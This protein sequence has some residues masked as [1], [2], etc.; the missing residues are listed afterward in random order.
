[1]EQME[2]YKKGCSSNYCS[3][4]EQAISSKYLADQ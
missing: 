4:I 2:Y 3:F 1:M